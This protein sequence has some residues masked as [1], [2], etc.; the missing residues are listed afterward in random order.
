VAAGF[1]S[2]SFER[3]DD[4]AGGLREQPE[5]RI[6]AGVVAGDFRGAVLRAVVDDDRLEVAERLGRE[7]GERFPEM[8]RLVADREEDGDERLPRAQRNGG[9]DPAQPVSRSPNSGV[10]APTSTISSAG[11]FAFRAAARIASGDGAS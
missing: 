5:A 7:R 2:R 6:L 9:C 11:T 3:G 8:R 4:A 10:S 1:T